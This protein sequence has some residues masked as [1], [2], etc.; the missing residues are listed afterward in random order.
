MRQICAIS[1]DRYLN[2]TWKRMDNYAFARGDGSVGLLAQELPRAMMSYPIGFIEQGGRYHLVGVQGFDPGSNLYVSAAGKWIG[3]Y[4]PRAYRQ[5][6]FL[7]VE[8]KEGTHTLCIDEEAALI[9]QSG[10]GDPFFQPDGEVSPEVTDIL[11]ALTELQREKAAIEHSCA[12]IASLELIDPWDILL[13]EEAEQR[14]LEGLFKI[15]EKRLNQ[16]TG[17]QLEK[18]KDAGGLAVVFCQLLSMQNLQRLADLYMERLREDKMNERLQSFG[19]ASS[20]DVIS[21]ENL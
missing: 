14:R 19:L 10:E 1:K 15:S 13:Q 8:N 3:E 11:K 2:K 20:G 18:L 5:H 12:C 4:L 17:E 7:L 16:L 6:P 9:G 21:F